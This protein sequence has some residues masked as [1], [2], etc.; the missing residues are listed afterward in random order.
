MIPILAVVPAVLGKPLPVLGH[1]SGKKEQETSYITI[2][3]ASSV[4]KLHKCGYM[5]TMKA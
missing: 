4:K 3:D 2:A 5:Y 1:L